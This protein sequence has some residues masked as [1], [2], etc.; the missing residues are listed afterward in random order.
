M[1]QL[2]AKYAI[3]PELDTFID[4][5]FLVLLH[6]DPVH[7]TVEF[8]VPSRLTVDH[9][10]RATTYS[11]TWI[12]PEFNAE[13]CSTWIETPGDAPNF[14]VEIDIESVGSDS[15]ADLDTVDHLVCWLV[16]LSNS[17]YVEG[18]MRAVTTPEQLANE[19]SWVLN[20][21]LEPKEIAEINRR[22][23][24]P[25][26]V[27]LCASGDFCDSNQAMIDAES[28]LGIELDPRF[29]EDVALLNAAWDIAK[30]SGFRIGPKTAREQAA[31]DYD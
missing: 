23:A 18:T 15:V 26:Y 2:A 13:F 3:P 28:K 14:E 10:G 24:L 6:E 30:C 8:H 1:S 7:K 19:F 27:G 16:D 22:N 20:E 4:R 11:L 12:H 25:E 9:E 31:C 5:G 29:N 17:G 21:W